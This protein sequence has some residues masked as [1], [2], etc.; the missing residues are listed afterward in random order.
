MVKTLHKARKIVFY[1]S[2]CLEFLISLL[3]LAGIIAHLFSISRFFELFRADG[4]IGFIKILFDAM[5]AVEFI[6]LLCRNDLKSMIEVLMFTV[7]RHLVI[8]PLETWEILIGVA[9]IAALF[10]VRKYLF[11][12]WESYE[13]MKRRRE[14]MD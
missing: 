2:G 9:A 6:K 3:A 7:T 11:M 5:I 12:H 1:A 4:L 10:A 14:Y 8:Q 13:Q